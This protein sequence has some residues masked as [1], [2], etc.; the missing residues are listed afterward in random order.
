[1]SSTRTLEK[2]TDRL[3]RLGLLTAAVTRHIL[4]PVLVVECGEGGLAQ[5]Y[6]LKVL[7]EAE[8]LSVSVAGRLVSH[9]AARPNLQAGGWVH[10]TVQG[11]SQEESPGRA[12]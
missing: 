8:Q 4:L 1:M 7:R 2:K 9:V 11:R 5:S 3:F 10:E 12:R 6:E